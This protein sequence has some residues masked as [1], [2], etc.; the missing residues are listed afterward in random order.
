MSG[1]GARGGKTGGNSV[2]NVNTLLTY[3]NPTIRMTRMR[4]SNPLRDEVE[5]PAGRPR[6]Q[7]LERAFAILDAIRS[8]DGTQN[9]ADVALATGLNRTTAWRLVSDLRS[10]GLVSEGE[11]GGLRLGAQLL[12]FGET[13]RRH[14]STSD[15][16]HEVLLRLRDDIGET[17]H[18]AVT[19]GDAMF[20]VDKVE[21]ESSVR[22][23]SFVGKRLDL[24]C[25]ALGKSHL[26]WLPLSSR[27]STI[28]RIKLV[29]HTSHT[30]TDRATLLQELELTKQRGWA[31]DDEENELGI[32]CIGAPILH[33]AVDSALAA[34]SVT[35]P[36]QR[37]SRENIH[38][39]AGRL[40][41]AASELSYL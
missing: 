2:H 16:A 7:S 10:L 11:D 30:I 39:L 36:V 3:A 35:A 17:C 28:A 32:R 20:Y 4:G 13:A 34:V 26:A 6:V 15:A 18:I 21:S 40:M 19:D 14:I 23:V 9:Y 41:R 22:V 12:S 38:N 31:I 33:K 25:T 37:F 5:R 24:H 1:Q 27:D 8:S 29:K